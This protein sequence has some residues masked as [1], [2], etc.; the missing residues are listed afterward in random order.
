MEKFAD[1]WSPEKDSPKHYKGFRIRQRKN[2]GLREAAV[3]IAK[4]RILRTRHRHKK[5]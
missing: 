5:A 3:K 1:K 2:I 4:E